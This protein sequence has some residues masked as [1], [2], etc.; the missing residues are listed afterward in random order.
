MAEEERSAQV[1]EIVYKCQ[2]VVLLSMRRRMR[3]HTNNVWVVGDDID[4]RNHVQVEWAFATRCRSPR[5]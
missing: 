2:P 4:A 5:F 1:G 3:N